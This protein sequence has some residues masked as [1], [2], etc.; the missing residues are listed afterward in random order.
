MVGT[1]IP[2]QPNV[3]E[4]ILYT[5]L[6]DNSSLSIISALPQALSSDRMDVK[7]P[8]RS[9]ERINERLPRALRR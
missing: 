2:V 4:L 7:G 9:I 8:F 6:P 1:L 5:G 3:S